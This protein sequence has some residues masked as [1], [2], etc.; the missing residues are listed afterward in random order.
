MWAFSAQVLGASISNDMVKIG[1]LNDQSGTYADLAG[2]GSVQA[3]RMA[4]EEMGGQV[5]GK[6]IELL[7][8]N[9]QNKAD[10]G[11]AIARSWF[12]QDGVD[13]IADFSNSSVGFA[14]Q[15]LAQ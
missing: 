3:A 7:V 6:K 9:H 5:A 1:I 11:A 14:V 12:D 15:R 10:V 13:M 8:G 4:I 2:P